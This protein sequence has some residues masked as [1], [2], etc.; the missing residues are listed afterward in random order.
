[1]TETQQIILASASIIRADMLQNAGLTFEVI[2]ANVDEAAI[3]QGFSVQDD[4][5]M[6]LAE[7]LAQEKAV[8]VSQKFG[9]AYVIGA[10]SVL[11]VGDRIFDKPISR[12]VAANHL[13]YL[14][15]R[16]HELISGAAIALGGDIIWST[17]DKATLKMRD[18]SDS[19]LEKYLDENMDAALNSVGC[20][21]LEDRGVHLFSKIRGDYF[22][23]LG[24]PLLPLLNFLRTEGV[25]AS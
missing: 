20:Y 6:E 10:D 15:N 23:I 13:R 1:M 25:L 4:S 18:F 12:S 8:A 11:A 2:P 14:R 22:T 19:F 9:R 7:R 3:K 16:D 24:L 5:P 21:H 17:V